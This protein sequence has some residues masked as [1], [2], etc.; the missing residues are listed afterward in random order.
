MWPKKKNYPLPIILLPK[1]LKAGPN[2]LFLHEIISVLVIGGG[3]FG[4]PCLLFARP[5]GLFC[6]PWVNAPSWAD[7]PIVQL[8]QC[9]AGKPNIPFPPS[10]GGTFSSRFS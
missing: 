3:N 4:N 9:R 5:Q 8:F 7:I 2:L 6:I 1:L 10:A